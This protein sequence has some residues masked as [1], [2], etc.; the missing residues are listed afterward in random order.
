MPPH[1]EHPGITKTLKTGYPEKI[2]NQP[3]DY[4][5]NVI[6]PGAAIVQDP[7]TGAI[8]LEDSL[9]DYLIEVKGYWFKNAD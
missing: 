6:C 3:V 7:D 9:E 8:V 4:F 1:I 5:G 2:E